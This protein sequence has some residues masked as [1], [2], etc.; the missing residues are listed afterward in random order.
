M[1][2]IKNRDLVVNMFRNLSVFCTTG[3]RMNFELSKA[4]DWVGSDKG[5][6]DLF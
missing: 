6:H 1:G 3:D 2:K 5:R 4:A